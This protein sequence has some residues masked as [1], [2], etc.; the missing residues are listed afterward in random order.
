MPQDTHTLVPCISEKEAH[1]FCALFNSSPCDLIVR[2]YSVSKG[3][4]SAH[5]LN[6]LSIPKYNSSNNIHNK[7]ADLSVKCHNAAK[8]DD[9]K[10]IHAFEGE[11]DK[12][13]AEIWSIDPDELRNIQRVL[14]TCSP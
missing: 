14:E 2:S 6:N 13:S 5:V 7:L 4:A 1:Y 3:F 12:L 8:K 11:I 9:Q 10:S